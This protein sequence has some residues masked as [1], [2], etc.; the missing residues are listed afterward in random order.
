M[1]HPTEPIEAYPLQWPVGRER[2][3]S[4]KRANSAFRLRPFGQIR[5][6]LMQELGRLGARQ[7]VLSSNVP[8]RGDG[9]PYANAREPDDGGVAVYFT[10]R[11]TPY[12]IACDTYNKVWK[13]LRAIAATVEALR[14]IERHGASQM[15]EQ[16]FQGFAALPPAR[17][18]EPS[19]WETLQV[20]PSAN[21]EQ[22]KAAR[23]NLAHQHHPDRGGDTEM[24]AR[25][26][27]AYER[28]CEERR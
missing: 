1:T 9:L 16:A 5:D 11:G 23:D 15:L 3:P 4:W 21:L 14:A 25:I 22:I 12:V 18:G 6:E 2:T 19:W 10:R 27:R 28:A 7:V 17:V 13:N 20:H 26:N 8:V 24:M